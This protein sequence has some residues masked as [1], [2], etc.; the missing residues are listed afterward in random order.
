MDVQERQAVRRKK[1]V[2]TSQN[3]S[4]STR[5]AFLFLLGRRVDLGLDL[6]DLSKHDHSV[7][8]H[9]GDSGQTFAVLVGIGD[10][11]LLGLKDN[12]GHLVGFQA[13]GVFH[14]L[15]SSLFSPPFPSMKATRD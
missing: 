15:S 8:V 3:Q 10:E 7:S 11:G 14:L 13:V 9:E 4:K 5:P 1:V 12:L 2:V 6:S